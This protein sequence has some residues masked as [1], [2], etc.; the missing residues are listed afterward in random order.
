LGDLKVVG[1]AAIDGVWN[2]MGGIVN[3]S[4]RDIGRERK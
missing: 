3:A 4:K 1:E 2:L